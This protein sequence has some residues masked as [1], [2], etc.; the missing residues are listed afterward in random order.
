MKDRERKSYIQS[1]WAYSGY[2]LFSLIQQPSQVSLD[3]SPP[4]FLKENN[5]KKKSKSHWYSKK[6]KHC[7][8]TICLSITLITFITVN[9]NLL[10]LP[11]NIQIMREL[12][13][14]PFR[15]L[16]CFKK[17][18]HYRLGIHTYPIHNFSYQLNKPRF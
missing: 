12:A 1:R 6:S 11:L 15:T 16:S 4:L 3:P 7:I 17:F 5:P 13:L 10:T 2:T 8:L 9:I 14:K 18:A